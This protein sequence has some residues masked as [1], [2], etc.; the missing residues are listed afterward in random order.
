MLAVVPWCVLFWISGGH[1]PIPWR[2]G[3]NA[4]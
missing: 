3:R 2:W 4:C 1:L